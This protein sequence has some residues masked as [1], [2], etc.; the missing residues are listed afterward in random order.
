VFVAIYDLKCANGHRFEV[1]QSFTAPLP[2]CPACGAVTSKI[3]STFGIGGVA[4]VPPPPERMP[5][6]WRGTYGGDREYVTELRRTAER[7][8]ALEDA[9]PELAGDRRPIV[10]HE[11]RYEQAPLRSGDPLPS[12]GHGHGHGHH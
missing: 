4:S 2:A 3:P 8:R 12:H 11:G 7:R 9:H 1:T 6:T 5:Q 10:A